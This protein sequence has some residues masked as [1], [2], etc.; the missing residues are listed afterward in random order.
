M[1][2]GQ[3]CLAIPNAKNCLIW[4]SISDGVSHDENNCL[5]CKPGYLLINKMCKKWFD[6]VSKYCVQEND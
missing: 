3:R 5:Q 6:S 1:N 2:Y 4:G